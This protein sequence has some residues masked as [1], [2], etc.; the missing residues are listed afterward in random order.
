[1]TERSRGHALPTAPGAFSDT[2]LDREAKGRRAPILTPRL[3]ILPLNTF[4]RNPCFLVVEGT[5]I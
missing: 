1:M 5:H 2:G 4:P 3:S